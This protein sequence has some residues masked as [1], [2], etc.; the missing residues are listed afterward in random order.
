MQLQVW[1]LNAGH[2]FNTS[3]V[4]N[5]SFWAIGN[6]YHSQCRL[7]FPCSKIDKKFEFPRQEL[8]FGRCLG[9]GMFGQVVAAYANIRGVMRNETTEI[10][11][12]SISLGHTKVAVKML[13]PGASSSDLSDLV[14]EYNLL[15]ELDHPNVIKLLGACTDCR[16]PLY[17]IMEF[18]EHGSLRNY[19][20]SHRPE[21]T[22]GDNQVIGKCEDI[23]SFGWQISKGM[24]YLEGLKV[25][26]R[27]DQFSLIVSFWPCQVVHRDLATRNVLLAEEEEGKVCKVSD[28]GMSRDVY[29]DQ[30]YT[31]LGSGKGYYTSL[32][33]MPREW[34]A[35]GWPF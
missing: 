34:L 28:F 4:D 14:M 25:R 21:P 1:K 6:Q 33:L 2:I 30:S 19:L 3:L 10:L 18:A 13:K 22:K 20:K 24:A 29:V 16:G 31:K 26:L 15:K 23:L 27:S 7:I 17:L 5:I 8:E 32:S 9:E 11:W 35:C 12:V